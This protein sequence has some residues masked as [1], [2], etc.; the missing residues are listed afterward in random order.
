M[1]IAFSAD[2]LIALLNPIGTRG[3]TTETIRG[4][5]ALAGAQPG[6]LSFLGNPKYKAQ[7]GSSRASVILVPKDFAGEPAAAQVFL[8]VENPSAALA[9]VCVRVEQVLWP[10]PIPGVHPSAVVAPTARIAAS[11]TIGPLCVIEAEAVIGEGSHLQAQVFL[12]RAATVGNGCWLQ[13]GC[14]VTAEC[15]LGDRVRLHPG[16]VIGS[17]GFG[18]EFVRGRHEK[19]PQVGTVVIGNDVEIGANSTVDR[20]RFG[21]TE[22]GEGTKLDNLVQVGHNVSIGRHCILC[23]QVGVSGSATIED[24]VVLGGQVGVGGHLAIGKGAKAAGGTVITAP[25]DGGA[26]I[27]GP[28]A[29]PYMLEQRILVLRKRLP[30]LFQRVDALEELLADVNK[31]PR[32]NAIGSVPSTV[33]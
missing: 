31:L 30:E 15:H 19:V 9:A 28:A 18:Y 4:I 13:P 8:L 3:T 27:K 33:T 12:G 7:V 20:A 1:R 22:I 10:R 24:Y 6:D 29:L 21:R 5:A 26:F 2:D 16:V 11:A 25:V 32:P 17:D 14:R 23:G